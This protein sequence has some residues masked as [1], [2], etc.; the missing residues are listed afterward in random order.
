MSTV[1][2]VVGLSGSGKT[3]GAEFASKA[4]GI[5]VVCSYTTR[6]MRPGETDGVEHHFVDVNDMPS[7]DKMLAYTFFGGH[8]YWTLKDLPE[9]CIY[10]I[11]EDGLRML[12]S[13][14]H[15]V[16]PLYVERKDIDVDDARRERDKG[17]RMMERRS[18]K[19]FVNN[20]GPIEKF[21]YNFTLAVGV[22]LTEPYIREK[23]AIFV[24]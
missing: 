3:T 21:L 16:M 11:D 20:D 9:K 6:P 13:S 12:L 4:L 8:H 18:Y 1:I 24:I 10:V 19:A 22:L 15:D 14:G 2:A 23:D 17:R 7:M 5:P